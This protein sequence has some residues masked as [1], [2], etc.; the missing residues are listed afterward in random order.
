MNVDDVLPLKTREA[1]SILP[2]HMHEGMALYLAF[3]IE[4]GGFLYSI[5]INDLKGA[6]MSADLANRYAIWDYVNFLYNFSPMFCWGT[7]ERV[8]AWIERGGLK[9]KA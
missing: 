7:T 8:Q 4:P 5:L 1:M 3:G 2:A 9:G 6:A